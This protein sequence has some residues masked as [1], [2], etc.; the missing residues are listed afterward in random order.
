MWKE[1]LFKIVVGSQA[2][3]EELGR[4]LLNVKRA[5]LNIA[6]GIAIRTVMKDF[7]E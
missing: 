7:Q 3:E 4:N 6:M 2:M 5:F 1:K